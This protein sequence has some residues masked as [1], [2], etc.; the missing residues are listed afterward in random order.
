[1][2]RALGAWTVVVAGGALFLPLM[3]LRSSLPVDAALYAAFLGGF[4][5]LLLLTRVLTLGQLAGTWRAIGQPGRGRP[6]A[7]RES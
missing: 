4:L 7:P 5:G 1:M 6:A 3:W 2:A